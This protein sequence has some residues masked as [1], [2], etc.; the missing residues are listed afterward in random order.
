MVNKY[1]KKFKRQYKGVKFEHDG[2]GQITFN[3]D[4]RLKDIHYRDMRSTK[5]ITEKVALE[6]AKKQ[7]E[8]NPLWVKQAHNPKNK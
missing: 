6:Y 5:P 3:R 4:A 7:I 1:P 2:R 8:L